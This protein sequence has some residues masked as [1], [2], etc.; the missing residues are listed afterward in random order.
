MGMWDHKKSLCLGEALWVGRDR[1]P[2][3][4][5]LLSCFPMAIDVDRYNV[6]PPSY[7]LV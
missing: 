5:E 3:L 7:K 2:E 6:R 1:K 4:P